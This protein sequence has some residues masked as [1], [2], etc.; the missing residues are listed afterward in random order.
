ME[1]MKVQRCKGSRDLS[2]AEMRMFRFI[3]GVFRQCCLSRGFEEVR[4]PTIEYLN[5]F[6]SAGMLTPSMLSK[7]YSFLDWDGWSGE[8]VVLRPDGTIPVVRLYIDNLSARELAKLFYVTNIFIFDETGEKNRE[9]WQC[10]AEIIGRGS[11]LVDAELISLSLEVLERLGVEGVELRL[12]HAGLIKT[13][14]TKLELSPEEQ[15]RLFDQ[16]LDGEVVAWDRLKAENRELGQAL[17]PLFSLKGQSPGFLNNL[18]ALAARD[19]PEIRPHLDSL[20]DTVGFLETLGC[21][22]QIDIASG[23]G[24][25]YY[26][27]VIFQFFR[28]REKIGGG[29]RYDDLVPAMGGRATPASGFALYLDRLMGWVKPEAVAGDASRR[30][31]IRVR[32]GERHLLAPAF[33]IAR[34][35]RDNGYIAEMDLGGKEPADLRWCLDVGGEGSL[36]ILQDRFNPGCFPAETASEVLALLEERGADKDSPA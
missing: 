29:G 12:S 6:T 15:T 7:V 31:L 18:G 3:E 21:A 4:T 24:F 34:Y 27:G 17:L 14:L 22:Y 35:L 8:R 32:S 26:T 16:I 11:P 36:F 33:T 20:M 13:L 30:V 1:F 19:L 10:G 28:G 2:P 23:A 5:L 25:E 9:Q